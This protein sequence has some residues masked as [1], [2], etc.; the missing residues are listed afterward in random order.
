M[1]LLYLPEPHTDFIFPIIGEE[2][3]FIGTV[4]IVALFL[5]FG[6]RGW[7]ISK[8]STDCFG[9]VLAIGIS[10]LIVFQA[11]LNIG[12]ATGLL[13][14]KGLPLPFV[15]FG[16]TALLFNMCGVGILLNISRRLKA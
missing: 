3:G 6:W 15:S 9:A 14:T 7:K 2:L 8:N 4:L 12:V 13:P 11:L 1:K 10:W 16:G 5:L